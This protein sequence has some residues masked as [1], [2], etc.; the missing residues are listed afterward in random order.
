LKTGLAL[1]ALGA[2]APMLQSALA[3][4]LS[5]AL[6]PDFGLLLVVALG[7]SGRSVAGGLLFSGFV[8]F[9]ADLLSGALLGQHALLRVLA[10]V[11]A[12]IANLH[13]NLVG[14]GVKGIFVAVLT[15]LNGLAMGGITAF[16][17]PGAGFAAIGAREL[18]LGALVNALAAPFVTLVVSFALTRLDDEGGGRRL[19]RLEPRRWSA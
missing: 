3:P 12:R 16:F 2:L 10:F 8:G 1:L 19:V 13:V 14:V 15:V 18:V 17:S 6:C 9:V 4:Y 11:A 7:L 5:A